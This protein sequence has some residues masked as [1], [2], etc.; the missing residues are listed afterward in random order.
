[1]ILTDVSNAYLNYNTDDREPISE[2]GLALAMQYQND[3]HLIKGSMGPKMEAG[4]SFV[5]ET[6]G[7]TIFTS[8]ENAIAAIQGKSGTKI[9]SK[10]LFFSP[11]TRPL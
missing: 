6:Q 9:I 2:I 3:G 8:P 10:Y 1:M 4:I 5:K 11:L 7:V